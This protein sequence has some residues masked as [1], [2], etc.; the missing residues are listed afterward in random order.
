MLVNCDA[1]NTDRW[2]E[3]CFVGGQSQREREERFW[4]IGHAKE[5]RGGPV[6]M[7]LSHLLVHGK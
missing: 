7:V 6:N 2:I 1:A 5:P 3:F 4:V